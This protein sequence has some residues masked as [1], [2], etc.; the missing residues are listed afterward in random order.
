[1]GWAQIPVL[2]FFDESAP[3]CPPLTP[4]IQ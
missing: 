1:V 4:P 2:V 3:F